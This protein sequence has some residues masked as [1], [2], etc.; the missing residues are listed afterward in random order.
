MPIM[1]V[2]ENDEV[3]GTI[4]AEHIPMIGDSFTWKTNGPFN[5]IDRSWNFPAEHNDVA[6]LVTL[7]V[8][9]IL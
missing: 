7:H 1:R 4:E 5:V 6:H 8:E 9:R 2:I 3:L